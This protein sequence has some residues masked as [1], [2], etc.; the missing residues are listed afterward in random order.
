MSKLKKKKKGVIIFSEVGA[1]KDNNPNGVFNDGGEV[2][3][4]KADGTWVLAT[5]I[6][7]GNPSIQ[8]FILRLPK[9]TQ[10]VGKLGFG[11]NKELSRK[12][13]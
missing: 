4:N 12:H 11:F 3:Y 5:R 9:T 8:V 2:G 10:G 7:D 1:N 6:E 13:I